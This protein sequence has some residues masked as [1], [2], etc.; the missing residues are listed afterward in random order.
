M[1]EYE[2]LKEE[3][4]VLVDARG[5]LYSVECEEEW[6]VPFWESQEEAEEFLEDLGS[7]LRSKY[8]VTRIERPVGDLIRISNANN[9]A[10]EVIVASN[11]VAGPEASE[12]DN[13]AK[14]AIQFLRENGLTVSGEC[15]VNGDPPAEIR[16]YLDDMISYIIE[17]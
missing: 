14:K 15:V 9:Q 6:M 5:C 17:R 4:Y 11:A 13:I 7:D 3:T 10:G 8:R 12:M 16:D 1:S 2:S